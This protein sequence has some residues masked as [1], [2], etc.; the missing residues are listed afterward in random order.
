MSVQDQRFDF[1][2]VAVSSQDGPEPSPYSEAQKGQ[3]AQVDRAPGRVHMGR[4]ET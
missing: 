1:W 3:K 4:K 2:D